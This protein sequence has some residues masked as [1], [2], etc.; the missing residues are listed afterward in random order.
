VTAVILHADGTPCGH[1][2]YTHDAG[3]RFWC[4]DGQLVTHVRTGEIT[5]SLDTAISAVGQLGANFITALAPVMGLIRELGAVL[6]PVADQRWRVLTA[7]VREADAII[8]EEDED[9]R[10]RAHP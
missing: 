7:A 6:G 4:G 2:G 9:I 10:G 3:G 1:P 5:T 8:A